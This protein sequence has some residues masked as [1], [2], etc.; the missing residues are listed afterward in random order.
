MNDSLNNPI[1]SRLPD[2]GMQAVPAA[3]MQTVRTTR[4]IARRM[5]TGIVMIA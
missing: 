4:E 2:P 5:G 3:V 1:V